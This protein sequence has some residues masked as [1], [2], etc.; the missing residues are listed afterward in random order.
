MSSRYHT[1]LR[2]GFIFLFL[3]MLSSY[4]AAAT[5][6]ER[7]DYDD[8]NLFMEAFTAFQGKDFLLSIEKLNRLE[9]LFPDSPLR[10]V[11][12]LMLSR[13]HQRSGDNQAAGVAINRFTKEFG[14]SPLATSVE[15]ELATLGKRVDAGEKLHQNKQLHTAALKVR[16]EQLAKERAIALKAE[17][18]RLARER[19][20]RERLAREKAEAERLERERLA[21]L[22]A[23]RESV[24]FEITQPI[25]LPDLE[26][27]TPVLLPFRLTNLGKQPEEFVLEAQ[28]PSGIE[29]VI[30]Q[31][32]DRSHPLQKVQL[33]PQEKLD[34]QLAFT[35]PGNRVDG[36]RLLLTA[37]AIS[38]KFTDISK[39]LE[40]QAT[41]AA[42]LLRAVCRLQP[43]S[44]PADQPADYRVTL[45]NVGSRPAKEIDLKINLPEPLR[46]VHAGD[47][48]CWIEND[49]LVACRIPLLPHGQLQERTLK[50][51]P[52]GVTTQSGKTVKGSVE[53]VQTKLQVKEN[54]PG[55][56]LPAKP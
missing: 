46:V 44:T 47:D 38:A 15:T 14:S 19:A 17:Q 33:Q 37:R 26:V 48:G 3:L 52:I 40:L 51:M 56:T 29:G 42:P 55:A 36:S 53:V 5:A 39:S 23:A 22:K 24:K 25:Q 1:I 31:D 7:N 34:L 21:A 12:L 18:E 16:N 2:L 32:G 4:H 13:A 28:L 43:K 54:F 30:V 50:V 45:L 6:G 8:S 41:S 10:D 20:E 9:Q 35:M 11:S 27:G 49:Q